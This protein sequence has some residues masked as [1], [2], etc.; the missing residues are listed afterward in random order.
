MPAGK[1]GWE[2][3]KDAIEDK[4]GGIFSLDMSVKK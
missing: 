4:I 3:R 2:G 1:Q